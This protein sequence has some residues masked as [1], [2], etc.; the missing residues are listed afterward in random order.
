MSESPSVLGE[1]SESAR[2]AFAVIFSATPVSSWS[3]RHSHWNTFIGCNR[4][5]QAST[6]PS[7]MSLRASLLRDRHVLMSTAYARACNLQRNCASTTYSDGFAMYSGTTSNS[8]AGFSITGVKTQRSQKGC[9]R[10]SVAGNYMI[11]CVGSVQD[12][13]ANEAF[14]AGGYINNPLLRSR[15][16]KNME[17]VVPP[18]KTPSI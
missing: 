17:V 16:F 8:L 14:S 15:S 7:L 2:H 11:F 4:W 10:R 5:A 18:G 12:I 1:R 9:V 13:E 6:H 3:S